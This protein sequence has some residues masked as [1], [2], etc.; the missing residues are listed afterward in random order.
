VRPRTADEAATRAYLAVRV[1][2]RDS[3]LRGVIDDT[4]V[5]ECAG[6]RVTTGDRPSLAAM[7]EADL[8]RVLAGHATVAQMDRLAP[9]REFTSCAIIQ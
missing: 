6:V 8:E 5:G 1:F 4:P 3:D 2:A 7:S 9:G